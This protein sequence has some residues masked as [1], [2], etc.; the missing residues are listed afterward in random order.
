MRVKTNLKVGKIGKV[1]KYG[2][3]SKELDAFSFVKVFLSHSELK[4]G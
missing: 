3:F 4:I 1:K 2:S